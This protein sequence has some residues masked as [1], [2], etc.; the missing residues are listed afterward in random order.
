[1]PFVED[2]QS[3]VKHVPASGQTTVLVT[4]Q[5]PPEHSWVVQPSLS[6]SQLPPLLPAD[7]ALLLAPALQTWHELSGLGLPSPTQ[8]KPPFDQILQEP[9]MVSPQ[10]WSPGTQSS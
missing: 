2:T 10:P 9:G 6:V 8:M 4:T 3:S 5:A 1:V 7:H